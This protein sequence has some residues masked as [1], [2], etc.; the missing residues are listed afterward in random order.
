M[1]KVTPSHEKP[2]TERLFE[3]PKGQLGLNTR[4][5]GHSDD[6]LGMPEVRG[7]RRRDT[8]PRT[9]PQTG[10]PPTKR[11]RT[12]TSPKTQS[13]TTRATRGSQSQPVKSNRKTEPQKRERK[14]SPLVGG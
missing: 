6:G 9:E 14:S 12:T 2:K 5:Q 10:P 1:G 7:G 13:V 11:S 3:Q 4:R 8:S